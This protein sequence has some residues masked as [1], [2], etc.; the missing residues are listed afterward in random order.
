MIDV[1]IPRG[2]STDFRLAFWYS[3]DISSAPRSALDDG[4]HNC[5]ASVNLPAFPSG[6]IAAAMLRADF[7]EFKEISMLYD[8]LCRPA[9]LLHAVCEHIY[10]QVTPIR[11]DAIPFPVRGRN[12][13][14]GASTGAATTAGITL[15]MLQRLRLCDDP[16]NGPRA[17][18]FTPTRELALQVGGSARDYRRSRSATARRRFR[19]TVCYG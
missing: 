19:A 13:F 1:V 3:P 5:A 6:P 9:D 4:Q 14:D 10:E 11:K 18:I 12:V 17:L 7:T 16:D 8:E 2:E 15:P